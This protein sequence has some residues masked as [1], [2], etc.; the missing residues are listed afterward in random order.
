M[1]NA[2]QR[3]MRILEREPVDRIPVDLWY[4]PEIGQQL[5][6]YCGVDNDWQMFDALGLDKLVWIS[7]VYPNTPGRTKWGSPIKQMEAGK[8]MY[9]EIDA[10]ALKDYDTP[11][12]LDDYPH[13]P[14]PERYDYAEMVKQAQS[15]ATKFVT[16]GPWVSFFEVYCQLRGLEQAMMDLAMAPDYVQAALDKIEQCQTDMMRRFFKQAGHCID[17]VFVSDDMGG[18]NNLL[19][20]L[21]MWDMFFKDRLKRWCELAHAFGIKVFYHSDGAMEALIPRLIE[22]GVD[23]L[24][25]IQ[26]IC[27]GMDR[28]AL[29]KEYG[30]DL[31]FHGGIE[32]QS[33]LPFGSLVQVRDET[34]ECLKTLGRGVEGYICCSCHNIQPGT[35]TEN[36][37]EMIQTVQNSTDHRLP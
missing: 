31:I 35:P 26:H 18:Q 11:E 29:K 8:A 34:L 22:A 13:W 7:D 6:A 3:L 30:R 12:S 25:P 5:R 36:I 9:A 14:D 28:A 32:N 16:L 15:A 24:N 4:T 27:P 17:L 20:S 21:G 10:A 33:V 19:M 1:M 37:I 2:R 23:V